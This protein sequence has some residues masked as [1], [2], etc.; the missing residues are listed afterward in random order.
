MPDTSLRILNDQMTK[1]SNFSTAV[2][3]DDACI[4]RIEEWVV[5]TLDDRTNLRPTLN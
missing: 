3:L 2:A 5:S 4:G 1:G